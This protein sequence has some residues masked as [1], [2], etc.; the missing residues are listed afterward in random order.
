MSTSSRPAV[1]VCIL[2][3][4]S[5]LVVRGRLTRAEMAR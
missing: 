1:D 3:A 2:R 5:K 4:P